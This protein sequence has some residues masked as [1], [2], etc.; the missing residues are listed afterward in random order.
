MWHSDGV[1]YE[2]KGTGQEKQHKDVENDPQEDE[3]NPAL[4]RS[5]LDVLMK[6]LLFQI[7]LQIVTDERVFQSGCFFILNVEVPSTEDLIAQVRT[8]VISGQAHVFVAHPGSE[9]MSSGLYEKDFRHQLRSSAK[10]E[11][12]WFAAF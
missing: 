8:E 1:I 4:Y 6:L 11:R 7:H 10:H 9:E 2:N 5:L 3:L 12:W